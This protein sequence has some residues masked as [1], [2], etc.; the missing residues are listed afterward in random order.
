MRHPDYHPPKAPPKQIA[1][2][3]S[4]N[5]VC[6][7]D[8]PTNHPLL[9]SRR[10]HPP[11]R[12]PPFAVW[13]FRRDPGSANLARVAATSVQARR[14][15]QS[16]P[17]PRHS[18]RHC[19]SGPRAGRTSRQAPGGRRR[20]RKAGGLVWGDRRGAGAGGSSIKAMEVPAGRGSLCED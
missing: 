14:C 16:R 18:L 3:E 12:W 10:R 7:S 5:F 15:R 4:S 2:S 9:T 19:A 6:I 17:F 1:T 13:R 20:G 8:T 11:T